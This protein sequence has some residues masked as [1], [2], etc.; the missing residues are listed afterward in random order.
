MNNTFFILILLLIPTYLCNDYIQMNLGRINFHPFE[1]SKRESY[2]LINPE[3]TPLI[4]PL[5]GGVSK[6]GLFYTIINVGHQEFK[7]IVVS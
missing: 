1:I 7:V 4:L 2:I 6:I 3:N 5:G